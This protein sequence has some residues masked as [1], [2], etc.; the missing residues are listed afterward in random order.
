MT[1]AQIQLQNALTT[2]FL[3]NLVFLSEYDNNLYHRV[4]ELS[5]MIENGSYEEKYALEFIMEKGDFDIYDLINNRYLY[6]KNPK[7]INDELVRKIQFDE[8]DSIFTLENIYTSKKLTDEIDKDTKFNIEN[9][10]QSN[11]LTRQDIY[12][13]SSILKDFLEDKKKRLKKI[14]KFLFIGTL[15]GRHIPKI[16][17]KVNADLYLVC[18][19]N[20]EIF[21]LSLFTVDYTILAKDC[22]VIFSIMD[23]L[24]EEEQKILN[25]FN[26]YPLENYL[27]KFTTTGIN[28]SEYIDRLLSS[29]ISIKPTSYDY[30]RY[31][32]TYINRVT[33]VLD[34]KY[35]ILLLNEMK[36]KFQFLKDKPVLF[37]GAGPS[38]D[39]NIEWIKIN[40]EKFFIVTI[41]A[42]YKKMISSGIKIDIIITLD[43]QFRVLNNSQFDDKSVALIDKNT[44]IIA[45]VLTNTKI[46]DKFNQENLFLYEVFTPFHEKNI[47]LSG[48]SVGEVSV[49][50][51]L[52]MNLKELYLIGLD[53]ALNQYTGHSHSVSSSSRGLSFTLGQDEKR[54]E[55][56]LRNGT[57]KVKGNLE[58]EVYTTPLFY[59]SIK[60]LENYLISND[61]DTKIYNLSSHGAYFENTTPQ[62]IS[63]MDIQ[64][65]NDIKIKDN[66]FL[67]LLQNF[68]SKSLSLNSKQKISKEIEFLKSIVKDNLKD[69][70][71]KNYDEFFQSTVSLVSLITDYEFSDSSISQILRNYSLMIFP[72]LSYHFNEIK[73]K[74]EDKKVIKI[75]KIFIKQFQTII[76][77][78]IYFLERV[79]K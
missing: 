65:F 32:Y 47:A 24:V 44:V 21:R 13:Y 15:L 57:I 77:D 27:I 6:N 23:N 73:M 70:Q 30:N 25:F 31:L 72:Y 50:L 66:D 4:D 46:L 7:K 29:F 45:S 56:G 8:K 71:S 18:E 35:K 76:E 75:E 58:E 52:N 74:N 14:K 19:R 20:L 28:I 22:G 43:E 16:A 38:L 26:I 64:S 62:I 2:T 17:E 68:S 42:A 34:N 12:S 60:Y 48:F 54:K 69:N 53:L 1:D 49:A 59:T 78:Y 36:E 40:Q 41:G 10:V 67:F 79:L 33:K 37:L 5:R 55:F 11:L 51:L 3:A 39:E 9:L 61:F 63:E